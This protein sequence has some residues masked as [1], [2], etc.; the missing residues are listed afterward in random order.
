M[1]HF[2]AVAQDFCYIKI[3]YRKIETNNKIKYYGNVTFKLNIS[4]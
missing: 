3:R 2:F 1:V 4:F